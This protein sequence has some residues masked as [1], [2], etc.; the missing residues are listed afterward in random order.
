MT[1]DESFLRAVEDSDMDVVSEEM[2]T[3]LKMPGGAWKTHLLLFPIV[4][5]VQNPPFI[6][7]HLP[8]MYRIYREL[9]PC[10]REEE[11]PELIRLE[12]TE[13]AKRPKLKEIPRPETGGTS[14][15]F[16]EI[17][18]ALKARELDKTVALMAAYYAQAG[19]V[20]LARRFLLLG[21]GYL[22]G[23]LG[24]SISCTAF[25]LLEMLERE[26]QDPWPALATLADY[27]NKGRFDTTPT[28]EKTTRPL[29]DEIID[30]YVLRAVSG[31]GIVKLHHTITFYAVERIRHLFQ[32]EEILHV[33]NAWISFLGNGEAER[34]D[35][36]IP[37][38]QPVRDYRQFYD[39]F[40]RLDAKDLT[41]SSAG[42]MDTVE[43]RRRLGRFLLKGLCDLYQ[44]DY[45]PHYLTGLGSLLFLVDRYEKKRPIAV[46]ALYQYLDFL[47][48][49]LKN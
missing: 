36:E 28:F 12:V 45:N 7:P 26:R 11:L 38:K 19:G 4:Q 47:F 39:I 1:D 22:N 20:E 31:R 30:N 46:N 43:G 37:E 18:T 2:V 42:M 5:R 25:I 41:A 34:I 15:S 8:K 6:N 9:A 44:G 23:S 24:H 16:G 32:G 3:R 48:N 40:S 35:T 17:E 13:F 29:S 21:T 27:F 10:L 33:L 14:V 49:G